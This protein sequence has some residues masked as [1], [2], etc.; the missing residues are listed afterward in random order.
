[1]VVAR[2]GCARRLRSVGLHNGSRE[3]RYSW[4]PS[5]TGLGATIVTATVVYPETA[6]VTTVAASVTV[7]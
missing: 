4:K 5:K 6:N 2:G 1:V 3:Y 7:T